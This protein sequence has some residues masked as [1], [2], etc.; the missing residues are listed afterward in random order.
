MMY[1]SCDFDN[2]IAYLGSLSPLLAS[3]SF[4]ASSPTVSPMYSMIRSSFFTASSSA[5]ALPPGVPRSR[6]VVNPPF[7]ILRVMR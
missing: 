2:L 5:A 1:T 6:T 7:H 4:M 3:Y